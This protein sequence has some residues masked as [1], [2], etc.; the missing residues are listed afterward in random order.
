[1]NMLLL[2]SFLFHHTAASTSYNQDIVAYAESHVGKKVGK[3]V[4]QELVDSALV[5]SDVSFKSRHRIHEDYSTLY[6]KVRKYNIKP[7]DILIIT[8]CDWVYDKNKK[9]QFILGHIAIIKSING[10]VITV[11]EQNTA[12][13]LKNSK[14]IVDDY[15]IS[16]LHPRRSGSLSFMRYK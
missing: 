14:V 5:T 4:C 1:M 3:G 16:Q 7:G 9:S 10:N 2:I 6:K 11:F 15:D 8:K 12:G 13:S